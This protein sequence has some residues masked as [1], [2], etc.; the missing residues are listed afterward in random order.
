MDGWT[1]GWV[2]EWM[3]GVK[4]DRG[5]GVLFATSPI[6]EAEMVLWEGEGKGSKRR[7]HG[8]QVGRREGR[9]GWMRGA[10]Y[11]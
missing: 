10:C 3:V 5:E 9:T 6:D 2:D 1:D 7:K 8:F 11:D 4:S